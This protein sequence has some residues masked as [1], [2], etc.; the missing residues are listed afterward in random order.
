M[1]ANTVLRAG[2][3]K[4]V[5]PADLQFPESAAQSPLSYITNNPVSTLNNGGS[6]ANTLDNPLPSG[7]TPAPGRNPNYQ[8]LLLGGSANALL[9]QENNG[10]TYQ[11]N[12][13]IQRQLPKG[14]TAEAAYVGP[15]MVR[16]CR[17][18]LI[19][20]RCPSYSGAGGR[21]PNLQC[22]CRTIRDLLPDQDSR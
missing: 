16:I 18:G 11:W 12:F 20:N 15:F 14:I 6:P 9:Q 5:I 21:G 3:G 1:D 22:P 19:S 8:Q 7:I 2:W 4:F 17:S 13:A 10:A